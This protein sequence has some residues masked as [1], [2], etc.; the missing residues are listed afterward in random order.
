[1]QEIKNLTDYKLALRDRIVSSAMHAF[2]NGIKAT[3]MDDI[4]T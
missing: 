3:K 4:A 2:A 1:M